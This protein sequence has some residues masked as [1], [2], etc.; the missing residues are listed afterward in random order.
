MKCYNILQN[1]LQFDKKLDDLKQ[2]TTAKDIAQWKWRLR[3]HLKQCKFESTDEFIE[4]VEE[5]L[6]KII[7]SLASE[8]SKNRQN[9]INFN[10][11]R[12]SIPESEN[13]MLRTLKKWT[14]SIKLSMENSLRLLDACSECFRN[15]CNDVPDSFTN[16]CKFQH[17]VVWAKCQDHL[18]WP[19][20]V[21]KEDENW[22]IVQ[23]FGRCRLIRKSSVDSK[24]G[25]D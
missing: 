25:K 17:K 20:K 18:F 7:R 2:Y 13:N 11:G 5:F 16:V 9:Y 23:C 4:M 19:A 21:L 3:D 8:F 1:R 22:V 14:D 15:Y 12:L 24:V 6:C 10:C